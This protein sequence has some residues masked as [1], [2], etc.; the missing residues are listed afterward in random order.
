VSESGRSVTRRAHAK[1]N[2]F[3]R[4]VGRR[5]DGYHDIESLIVPISLHD[6]VMLRDAE[7]GTRSVE[8]GGDETLVAALSSTSADENLAARALAVASHAWSSG[9]GPPRGSAIEIVKRVPVAAGLGGGSADAAATLEAAS[10]LWGIGADAEQLRVLASSIGSDVPA[11]LAG[12]PVLAE[13]RGE[14]LTPVHMVTMWW[15]IKPLEFPVRARDAYAWWGE[16]SDTGPDAGSLIAAAE[17]GDLELL[18]DA[19]FN[20]LQAPVV[21]RHPVIAETVEAFIQV[22]ALG[23]IMSGS[24]STV[25]ALA[26]HAQHASE[27]AEAIEGSFVVTGPPA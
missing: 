17:T 9:E 24:G 13:G 22:G 23:A 3:L 5:D 10:D 1:I 25:M 27:L 8:V 20:D 21:E 14:R 16:R 15:V 4:V 11:M 12:E 26:R 6:D 7:P 2:L 18:G 19:I